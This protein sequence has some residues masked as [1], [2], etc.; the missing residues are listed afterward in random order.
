ML[1]LHNF[2]FESVQIHPRLQLEFGWRK[3]NYKCY[4]N[5]YTCTCITY[6]TV[7]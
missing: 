5:A 6:L 7:H 4:D 3:N 2:G 1:Y